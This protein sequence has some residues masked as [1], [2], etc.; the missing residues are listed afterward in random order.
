MRAYVGVGSNLGDRWANLVRAARGLRAEPRLALVRASRVWDTPPLGPPQ[1]R[2]LNAVLEVEAEVPASALLDALQRVE[3]AAGRRRRR[4]GARW[5]A[6]NLDLD[7]LLFG[8]QVIRRPGLVVPH[9]EMASRRFV[10]APL[11]ELCPERRV[12]GTGRTVAELLALAPADDG[13]PVGIYPLR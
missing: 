10:L 8:D 12:P 4:G 6:R 13:V 7:L 9:P 1:P 11:A 5:A 2:Y 3:L